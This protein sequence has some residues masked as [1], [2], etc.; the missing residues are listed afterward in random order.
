MYLI[1]TAEKFDSQE[2]AELFAPSQAIIISNEQGGGEEDTATVDWSPLNVKD[3]STTEPSPASTRTTSSKVSQV[4]NASQASSESRSR[5]KK[6]RFQ[7][8]ISEKGDIDAEGEG[9]EEGE[10]NVRSN[11][12]V[13]Q[14]YLED[15]VTAANDDIMSVDS[16]HKFCEEGSEDSEVD[17][18]SSDLNS[19]DEEEYT[20][21]RLRAAGPPL[22]SLA[23]LLVHVLQNGDNSV[24]DNSAASDILLSSH[25]PQ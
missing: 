16:L 24:R 18:L 9:E 6:Y 15:R 10:G 3:K 19:E 8:P 4:S 5:T 25:S 12:P 21:E 2:L 17:S 13:I 22:S 20:L 23:P 11:S 14:A 7:L 1:E